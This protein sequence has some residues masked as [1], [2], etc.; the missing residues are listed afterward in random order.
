MSKQ[1][2]RYGSRLESSGIFQE[3]GDVIHREFPVRHSLLSRLDTGGERRRRG[4]LPESSLV[5]GED[6]DS[7]LSELGESVV[8]TFDVFD[9][10]GGAGFKFSSDCTTFSLAS[11][12]SF[13]GS[14]V[15]NKQSFHRR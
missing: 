3:K 2:Q 5:V 11:T 1:E 6:L 8:V 12:G 10:S 15:E 7:S 14:S 13:V 4:G 9:E